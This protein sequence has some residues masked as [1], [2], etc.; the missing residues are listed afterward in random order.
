[1]ITVK[2][3]SMSVSSILVTSTV[4]VWISSATTAA[5]VDHAGLVS[6]ATSFWDRYVTAL[7]AKILVS[8]KIQSTKTTTLVSVSLASLGGTVSI[9]LTLVIVLH[10][11]KVEIARSLQVMTFNVLAHQVS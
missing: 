3:T 11:N 6:I 5:T 7:S 2:L 10:V 1:M 9:S 8:A 4:L